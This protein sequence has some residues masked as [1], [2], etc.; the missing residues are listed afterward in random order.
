MKFSRCILEDQ[1]LEV[2]ADANGMGSDELHVRVGCGLQLGLGAY[3]HLRS[4]GLLEVG[5]E[6]FIG[7]EFGA[8]AGQGEDL[9]VS[10]LLGQSRLDGFAVV[11]AQVVQDEEDLLVPALAVAHQSL[12]ELDE[13]LV[14]KSAIDDHPMGPA[15]VGHRGDHRTFRA[16]AASGR[17]SSARLIGFCGVKPR[18]RRYSPEARMDGFTR[19]RTR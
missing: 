13:S 14:V 3:W 18:R 6:S 11:H 5:I 8:V 2:A 17:C 4:D 12:Q 16:C 19:T 10:L 1:V 7:I 9:D 15:L